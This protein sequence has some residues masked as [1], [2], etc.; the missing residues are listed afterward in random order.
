MKFVA[1]VCEIRGTIF[2]LRVRRRAFGFER[3]AAR[4]VFHMRAHVWMPNRNARKAGAGFCFVCGFF[5]PRGGRAALESI[6]EAPIHMG[7]YARESVRGRLP[8]VSSAL[9]KID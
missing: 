6:V 2:V 8:R 5:V 1:Q 7:E 4:P 9:A 3:G